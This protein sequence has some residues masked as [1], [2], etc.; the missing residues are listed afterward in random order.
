MTILRIVNNIKQDLHF[1]N[2][3]FLIPISI[4]RILEKLIIFKSILQ[5][6]LK[7][8]MTLYSDNSEMR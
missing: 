5:E 4:L 7:I 3:I 8:K 2:L 6:N 1:H